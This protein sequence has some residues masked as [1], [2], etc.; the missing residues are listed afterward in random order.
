MNARSSGPSRYSVFS[1]IGAGT[2]AA[3]RTTSAR[4]GLGTLAAGDA[5]VAKQSSTGI[6]AIAGFDLALGAARE[7]PLVLLKLAVVVLASP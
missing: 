1:P 6:S 2:V 3:H 5:R 4:L 7:C